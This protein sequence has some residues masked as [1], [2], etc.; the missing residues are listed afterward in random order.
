MCRGSSCVSSCFGGLLLV[1]SLFYLG[2]VELLPLPKGTETFLIQ[3]IL[4]F[5]FG[6][7]FDHLFDFFHFFSF[8]FSLCL[9]NVCVVNTLTKGG[10]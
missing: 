1:V 10:H 5:A 6:S 9:S 8:S 2:C 3:V 7:T 4:F